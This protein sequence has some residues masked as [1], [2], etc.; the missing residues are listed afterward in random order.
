MTAKVFTLAHVPEALMQ[1]WLQHL[2][3]F[4]V[5]HPDCHFEVMADV[6]KV[7]FGEALTQVLVSPELSFQ[8]VIERSQRGATHSADCW[9]WGP[10]HYEC[11]VAKIAELNREANQLS[12]AFIE[13]SQRSKD[14]G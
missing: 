3:D 11:A 1:A 4:D 6:P 13:A 12:R 9:S 5:A 2:R 14:E 10:R 8:Q 7:S